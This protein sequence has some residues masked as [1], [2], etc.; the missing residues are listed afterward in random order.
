MNDFPGPYTAVTRTGENEHLKLY[1][2]FKAVSATDN[3]KS[4]DIDD[5]LAL[6]NG[7]I[8]YEIRYKNKEDS[9]NHLAPSL[10][11]N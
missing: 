2:P 4:F 6:T 10:Q 1:F 9:W 3:D 5:N 11:N 8:T 7:D